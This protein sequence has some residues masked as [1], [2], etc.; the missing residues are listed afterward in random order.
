MYRIA[1]VINQGKT[2]TISYITS[3]IIWIVAI[4]LAK[5]LWTGLF[6]EP[7]ASVDVLDIGVA[8]VFSSAATAVAVASCWIFWNTAPLWF[9]PFVFMSSNGLLVF[10]ARAALGVVPSRHLVSN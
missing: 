3:V 2:M 7:R 10:G 5:K 4:F 1:S 8:Y 9:W 6:S